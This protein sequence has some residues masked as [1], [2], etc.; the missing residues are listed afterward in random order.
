MHS[1]VDLNFKDEKDATKVHALINM[2]KIFYSRPDGRTVIPELQRAL[3]ENVKD[4]INVQWI[5]N[6]SW[7]T[8][9]EAVQQDRRIFVFV[10]QDSDLVNLDVEFRDSNLKL[11]CLN[12]R[13][14]NRNY[15][16]R[17]FTLVTGHYDCCRGLGLRSE[18]FSISQPSMQVAADSQCSVNLP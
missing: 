8:L 9:E 13:W 11:F 15:P 12:R 3:E 18:K 14:L 1:Q 4:Q 2:I 17:L 10:R 7:P 6:K 5:R 16:L